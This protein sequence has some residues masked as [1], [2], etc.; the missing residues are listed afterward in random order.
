MEDTESSLECQPGERK[1]SKEPPSHEE[2]KRAI[3]NEMAKK[4]DFFDEF[5]ADIDFGEDDDVAGDSF[6]LNEDDLLMELDEMINQ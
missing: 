1:A 4:D 6:E 2:I 3:A 5:G